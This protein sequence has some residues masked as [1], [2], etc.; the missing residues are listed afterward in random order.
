MVTSL[1]AYPTF[2][3]HVAGFGARLVT[4]PYATTARASTGCSPPCAARTR[5]LVYL[6]NPDNPMGTLVGARPRSSR[7]IEALPETT[8][9]MLD[10]AY[11]ETAPP[12]RCRRSTCRGPTSSACAPSRRPTAL[13]AY[14]AAMPSARRQV[15]RDF[16]K[17]RNHYGV[18][19]MA[20]VAGL[21]ALADQA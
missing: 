21:A 3:F 17:I 1:G 6:S 2:N 13:P 15:I 16:E 5:A 20:Q 11:G 18:N 12:R 19:R 10:E 8:M 9:L 4:V 14:A 7:F